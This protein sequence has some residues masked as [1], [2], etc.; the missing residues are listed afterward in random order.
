MKLRWKLLSIVAGAGL[1]AM[2][3]TSCTPTEAAIVGGIAG[4]AIGAAV[5]DD[6]YYHGHRGYHGPPRGYYRP[7]GGYCY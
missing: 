2:T 1:L 6:H 4:A 3:N 7:R 5:A